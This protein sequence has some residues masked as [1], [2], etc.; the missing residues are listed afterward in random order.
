MKTYD[1]SEEEAI[2]WTRH[3]IVIWGSIEAT[4]LSYGPSTELEQ[5]ITLLLTNQDN[6]I[7]VSQRA[8]LSATHKFLEYIQEVQARAGNPQPFSL[9]PE[10]SQ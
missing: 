3:M 1:L 2:L 4:Y 6:R 8:V 9:A 7:Y 10:K 5:N